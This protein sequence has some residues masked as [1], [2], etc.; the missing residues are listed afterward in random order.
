MTSQP[1]EPAAGVHGSSRS[2][3]E[4]AGY[5]RAQLFSGKRSLVRRYADLVVGMEAGMGELARY[6]L[7]TMLFGRVSGALG[8]ALR[9]L[10]FPGLFKACGRGVVFGRDLTLRNTGRISLG[11]NA[12]LDDGCVIDGRGAG[13]EGVR[14]GA[15]TI[16]GRDVSI[17]AKIGPVHIGDDCDI[18]MSTVL[19]AQGGLFI[20]DAVVMGGGC[21]VSGGGFQIAL[22]A[23]SAEGEQAARAQT[24]WT[25]GPIRIGNRCLIGMGTIILDGVEIGDGAVIGAGSVLNRSIPANAVAA[26]SPCRV[27]RMR[28]QKGA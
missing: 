7:I 18:G 11:E 17:Q 15:R 12:V 22:A 1:Q 20:G 2:Q 28:D 24:R 3:L 25:S 6:E 5:I 14:I 23:G 13:D 8:L 4:E 9:K 19:H 10:A 27:L 21:K 16:L 26:G